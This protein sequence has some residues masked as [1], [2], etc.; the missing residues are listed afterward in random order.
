MSDSVEQKLKNLLLKA[1]R[2]R[3]SDIVW[4]IYVKEVI[5]FLSSAATVTLI[6]VS[7]LGHPAGKNWRCLQLGW[8]HF[9]TNINRSFTKFFVV[10]LPSALVERSGMPFIVH[11]HLR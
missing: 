3:W 2:E 4:G 8:L 11:S 7:Y 9:E 1:W 5:L 10:V 6:H